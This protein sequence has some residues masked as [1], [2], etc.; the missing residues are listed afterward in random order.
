MGDPAARR[1]QEDVGSCCGDVAARALWPGLDD[2]AVAVGEEG[3]GEG[4]AWVEVLADEEVAVVEG[5]GVEADEE[6][7]GAGFG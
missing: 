2:G 6:F 4:D 5:G 7:L 1:R 3:V